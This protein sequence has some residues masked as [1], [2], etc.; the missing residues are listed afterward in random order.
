MTGLGCGVVAALGYGTADYIARFTARDLGPLRALL[1]ALVVGSL[2]ASAALVATQTA[3]PLPTS[4]AWGLLPLAGALTVAMLLALYAALA[5]GPVTVVAPIVGAYPALVL[6]LLIPLGTL[7]SAYQW[8][9][10]VVTAGGVALLGTQASPTAGVAPPPRR[11][12]ATVAI[13]LLA[14]SLVALQVIVVQEAAAHFGA[15]ATTWASRVY[16]LLGLVL[17]GVGTAAPL[18]IPAAQ[19][20]RLIAQGLLDGSALLAIATAP[21]SSDRATVAIVTSAFSVVTVL[22]ARVFLREQLTRTQ[23]LA[24]VLTL[25][26]VATL[27]G[28]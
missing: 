24:I 12:S 18:R 2:L 23:G 6:V 10:L 14:S 9:G 11:L 15:L 1:G 13:A 26:G 21:A 19:W 7:P 8:A 25:L 4:A 17:I 27:V 28:G 22:L 3:L 16:A 5:R 20:P